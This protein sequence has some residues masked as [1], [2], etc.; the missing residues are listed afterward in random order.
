VYVSKQRQIA[1]SDD[2]D[3]T[4]SSALAPHATA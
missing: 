3:D 1:I 4:G 2:A